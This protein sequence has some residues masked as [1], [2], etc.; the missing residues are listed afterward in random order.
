ME[1]VKLITTV[2]IVLLWKSTCLA[3]FVYND[4]LSILQCGRLQERCKISTKYSGSHVAYYANSEATYQIS[5]LSSGDVDPNPGPIELR[6]ASNNT[7]RDTDGSPQRHDR[8]T[9]TVA[10]LHRFD[11]QL[12]RHHHQQLNN[13]VWQRISSLGIAR[14]KKTHRGKR[15]TRTAF[16]HDIAMNF[17]NITN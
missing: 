11:P 1:V 5:L 17:N 14:R 2:F 3:Q 8:T 15:A 4:K 9:Y 16:V 10:D 6:T 7:N 13:E 12:H